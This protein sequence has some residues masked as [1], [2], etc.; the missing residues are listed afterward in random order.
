MNWKALRRAFLALLLVVGWSGLATAAAF[1]IDSTLGDLR[2]EA[3]VRPVEPRPV[4]LVFTFQVKGADSPR[5]QNALK[6]HIKTPVESS[7]L[8]TTVSDTP[9]EGGAILAV[10]IQNIA[11]T[12]AAARRGARA[13]LTF[14]LAGGTVVDR[15]VGTF[16]YRGGDGTTPI[17]RTLEHRLIPTVGRADPPADAIRFRRP[18]DAIMTNMRQLVTHGVNRVALDPAF[19]GVERPALPAPVEA[20]PAPAAEPAVPTSAPQATSL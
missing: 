7:G 6:A 20:T 15:Y 5:G 9:V 2:S 8:F 3:K 16:E 4:Q 19:P 12:A 18:L 13:G 14:G 1:Y 10:N 17:V 11:D